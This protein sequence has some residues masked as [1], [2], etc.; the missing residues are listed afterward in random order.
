MTRLDPDP[1][2][3][4]PSV[5]YDVIVSVRARVQGG[6]CMRMRNYASC[7]DN[8]LAPNP[9]GH[10]LRVHQHEIC[11]DRTSIDSVGQLLTQIADCNILFLYEFRSFPSLICTLSS[12]LVGLYR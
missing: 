9:I 2:I 10:L 8:N 7:A 1:H 5:D 6:L 12:P 4:D 11:L 3:P